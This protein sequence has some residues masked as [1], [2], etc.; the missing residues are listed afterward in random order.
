M[1]DITSKR[2]RISAIVVA[3]GIA[4]GLALNAQQPP[5]VKRTIVLKQDMSIPDREAVMAFVE[6]PPGSA[7]GRHSHPAEAYAF[8]Q[9]GAISLENE[10]NPTVTLKAGDVFH[11]LPGKV[12]QAINNGSVTAKLAVVFVAEKGKPLTTPAK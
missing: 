12:H 7:E 3:I 5:Q 8:V 6:L 1:N 9:E 10:G 4:G 2:S 11:L